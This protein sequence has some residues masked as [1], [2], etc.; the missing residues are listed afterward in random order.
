MAR[1]AETTATRLHERRLSAI[2]C[3]AEMLLELGRPT[4]VIDEL[5]SVA[6]QHPLREPLTGLLML[7]LY[8]DGRGAEALTRYHQTRQALAEELGVEPGRELRR[9]F[10]RIL[11]D[12]PALTVISPAEPIGPVAAPPAPRRNCHRMCSGSPVASAIWPCS[13]R[14]SKARRL[15][16]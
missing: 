15:P 9:L 2:T 7:A 10:E 16:R 1:A 14:C 5:I 8:R 11:V 4:V 13:M 3:W 6:E 12:D